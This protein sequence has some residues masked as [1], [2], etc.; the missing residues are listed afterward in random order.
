MKFLVSDEILSVY[1]KTNKNIDY[2]LDYLLSIIDFHNC[3][4]YFEIIKE[5]KFNGSRIEIE[6]TDNNV[7]YIKN[8]FN[9]CDNELIEKLLWISVLF[10]E[11]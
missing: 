11:V 3:K 7:K 5:I 8:L 6:V 2:M 10:P 9:K 4:M 1:K